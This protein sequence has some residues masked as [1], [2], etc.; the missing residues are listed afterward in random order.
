VFGVVT[1]EHRHPE[2]FCRRFTNAVEAARRDLGEDVFPA[3]RLH[4]V[5]H[6]HATLLLSRG[7]PVKVVQERLGR[8]PR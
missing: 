2:R 1:G 5:R 4:D 6:T 8:A 7:T 3:I